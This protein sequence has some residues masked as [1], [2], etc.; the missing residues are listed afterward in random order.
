[1]FSCDC[2][3]CCHATTD[4]GGDSDASARTRLLERHRTRKLDAALG[5]DEPLPLI[6]SREENAVPVLCIRRAEFHYSVRDDA[7]GTFVRSSRF[8][9]IGELERDNLFGSFDKAALFV[10]CTDRGLE[11]FNQVVLSRTQLIAERYQIVVPPA[12]GADPGSHL[13]FCAM[14]TRLVVAHDAMHELRTNGALAA[15]A[16]DDDRRLLALAFQ[17]FADTHLD[18][19]IVCDVAD[20]RSDAFL[21]TPTS[22]ATVMTEWGAALNSSESAKV[23]EESKR[24][25]VAECMAFSPLERYYP[26]PLRAAYIGEML[27]F[28]NLFPFANTWS[29]VDASTRTRM[30]SL[31]H[32]FMRKAVGHRCMVRAAHAI[33]SAEMGRN[34][35]F[36]PFLMNIL[37]VSMLGN[38]E[39]ANEVPMWRARL[40]IRRSHHWHRKELQKWCVACHK[41]TRAA[42]PQCDDRV[43]MAKSIKHAKHLCDVCAY[44]DRNR[45]LLSFAVKAFYVH[46][47][48][49]GAM[50]DSML[51]TDSGWVEHKA[52]VDSALDDT[53]RTLSLPFDVFD[54]ATGQVRKLTADAIIEAQAAAS[55]QLMLIHDCDKATMT[56]LRKSLSFAEMLT[57]IARRLHKEHTCANWTGFQGPGD[58]LG[59]PLLDPRFDDEL[60]P[61]D[62]FAAFYVAEQPLE[63][64]DGKRWCDVYSL[65]HIKALVRY[66]HRIHHDIMPSLM[67]MIGFSPEAH[68]RLLSMEYA[69]NVRDMPDN[70][71]SSR[72]AALCSDL[73]VDFHILHYFLECM[74]DVAAIQSVKLDACQTIAQA[75]ALR[76][77]N[78]IDEWEVLPVDSDRIFA[79]RGHRHV[80]TDVSPLVEF[81][82]ERAEAIAKDGSLLSLDSTATTRGVPGALYDNQLDALV[83]SKTILSASQKSWEKLGIKRALWFDDESRAKSV[84][85]ARES[86]R[87]CLN[88][89]L[90]SLSVL[91]RAW[92]VG[93]TVYT[94][95]VKCGAVCE[96]RDACMSTHGMTCGREIRVI[97]RGR[98]TGLSSFSNWHSGPVSMRFERGSSGLLPIDESLLMPPPPLDER[99]DLFESSS[100][101]LFDS[102]TEEAALARA[103]IYMLT[104]YDETV[105]STASFVGD[106]D[107]P[108]DEEKRAATAQKRK[109]PGVRRRR[110]NITRRKFVERHLVAPKDHTAAEWRELQE[111][112]K[113]YRW[114]PAGRVFWANYRK[115]RTSAMPEAPD[116]LEKLVHKENMRTERLS[117][118]NYFDEAMKKARIADEC[119]ESMRR[120][121]RRVCVD[122]LTA[123][124]IVELREMFSDFG[125]IERRIEIACAY[126]RA[127]CEQASR[128]RRITVSNVSNTLID[129]HLGTPL[130][131][132]G[133]IHVYLCVKCFDACAP[134]FKSKPLPLASDVFVFMNARRQNAVERI[135]RFFERK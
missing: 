60:P 63:H 77:R 76:L 130:D 100:T 39:T 16:I 21:C 19:A 83:C 51:E 120:S 96:W 79:C 68:R 87:C 113:L 95:C 132:Y 41:G 67:S 101:P 23:R 131:D 128:F 78:R 52:L 54:S 121:M 98:Y 62:R 82:R 5:V 70:K 26:H 115:L 28:G 48:R 72:L 9:P 7:L 107:A 43:P 74:E 102:E 118:E 30:L 110:T 124:E 6:A 114:M 35:V 84:L 109:Q 3:S 112:H 135:I 55:K 94:L 10:G 80:Y 33:M 117:A 2:E 75:S 123:H 24:T 108:V 106:T 58:I 88:V 116:L 14:L 38:C 13:N 20:N 99:G 119:V 133:H 42:C 27:D 34:P 111:V 50:L 8:A 22:R 104:G 31:V 93:R 97:E 91:G 125:F 66:T 46:N 134:L 36:V 103:N 15:A 40:S 25:L 122:M 59:A 86:E 65:D 17:L 53:R 47:V 92:L 37:E 127:R 18:L 45:R 61:R 57:P 71:L 56:R 12:V 73:P 29:R 32:S 44:L 90:E 89:P 85:A 81:D 64:L 69:S 11:I 105:P 126:C 49:A 4:T 129:G 1:M